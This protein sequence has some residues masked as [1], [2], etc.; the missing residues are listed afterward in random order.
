MQSPDS[1]SAAVSST[2]AYA[3]RISNYLGSVQPVLLVYA[4]RGQGPGEGETVV[5]DKTLLETLLLQNYVLKQMVMEKDPQ[6]VQILEDLE[7]VL[8]EIINM[9]END[10]EKQNMIRDLI[11]QR[12]ILFKMDVLQEI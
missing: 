1:I 9:P 7:M 10:T 12:N 11:K 2:P 8:R 5:M 6:A 4:N 3:M